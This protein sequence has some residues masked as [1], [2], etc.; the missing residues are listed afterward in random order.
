MALQVLMKI[1]T[2]I[3]LSQLSKI[4]K[5]TEKISKFTPSGTKPITGDYYFMKPIGTAMHAEE[6]SLA[7]GYFIGAAFAP[8][9]IG[10]SGYEYPLAKTNGTRHIRYHL[11]RLGLKASDGEMKEMLEIV[12]EDA[13]ITKSLISE[14]EFAL[15]ARKVLGKRAA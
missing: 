11:D 14:S 10:K 15:I 3:D 5:L 6:K 12:K 13:N 2:N 8:E 4:S 9:I 1:K 7:A